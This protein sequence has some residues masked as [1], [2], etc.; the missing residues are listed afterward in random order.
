M[1]TIIVL[2]L[3]LAS[4]SEASNEDFSRVLLRRNQ[5]SRLLDSVGQSESDT[6]NIVTEKDTKTKQSKQRNLEI[7]ELE[8]DI[9]GFLNQNF[10]LSI[11]TS[12]P[13][14]APISRPTTNAPASAPIPNP[15]KNPTKVTRSP[16]KSPTT[17]VPLTSSPITSKPVT[18]NPTPPTL[19][20][21]FPS[22]SPTSVPFGTS[23]PITLPPTN[24][25]IRV[26]VTNAPSAGPT[27][28]G[29]IGPVTP[30]PIIVTTAT[31]TV[32]PT[33]SPTTGNPIPRPI[34]PPVP[35]PSSVPSAT[36]IVPPTPLPTQAPSVTPIVAPTPLPSNVPTVRPSSAPI[37]LV[38]LLELVQTRPDLDQLNQAI[39]LSDNNKNNSPPFFFDILSQPSPTLTL[40]APNDSGFLLTLRT[41]LY[42]QYTIT[43]YSFHLFNLLAFHIGTPAFT[44]ASFPLNN[45]PNLAQTTTDVLQLPNGGEFYVN[46]T[47]PDP[48]IIVIPNIRASNGIAQ[49]I[50]AVAWPDFTRY[51][52]LQAIQQLGSDFSIFLNFISVAGLEQVYA[53]TQNATIL[54]VPNSGISEDTVD[55]LL[56]PGNEMNLTAVLR[57]LVLTVP[58]N[59]ASVRVP[60]LYILQT[61]LP[62]EDVLS[63]VIKTNNSLPLP[64]PLRLSFS[65]AVVT[66][67]FLSRNCIGYVMDQ[68]IFPPSMTNVTPASAESIAEIPFDF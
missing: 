57:Y 29:D 28:T 68:I 42:Q 15:T 26:P 48:G 40:F 14:K 16:I 11:P 10:E 27:E 2:L 54:V 59:Y 50:D 63:A 65:K 46:S 25:P 45:I 36:P 7:I 62:G 64:Q 56:A 4:W 38:T 35:L 22:L 60:N 49:I 23:I 12:S 20:S 58:F 19:E 5:K 37:P 13:T 41:P 3:S 55:F 39:I 24:I 66:S 32:A 51:N 67:T 9:I 53:S 44:T 30:M 47:N 61:T 33:A 52:P 43:N 34:I 17:A 8:F 18:A 1:R 6:T 31:P 21:D